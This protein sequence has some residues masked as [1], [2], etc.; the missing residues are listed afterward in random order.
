MTGNVIRLENPL[1]RMKRLARFSLLELLLLAP[2]C[3]VFL[4]LNL[5]PDTGEVEF[6]MFSNGY[7]IQYMRR[8]WPV[9]FHVEFDQHQ[10]NGILTDSERSDRRTAFAIRATPKIT[11]TVAL[12]M[13]LL[14]LLFAI[15]I[16]HIAIV[17]QSNFWRVKTAGNESAGV[18]GHE[19]AG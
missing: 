7:F 5:V 4:L 8:G 12:C 9:D 18:T 6:H 10:V 16:I 11:S 3:A 19:I 15:G 17:V 2:A 14:A 1:H 13:N